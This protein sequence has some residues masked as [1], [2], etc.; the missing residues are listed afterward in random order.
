MTLRDRILL[1]LE[2]N[3]GSFV[4]GQEIAE[5]AGVSRSAVAKCVASL[6]AEGFRIQSVN[7]Q[8][9]L[10]ESDSDILSESGILAHLGDENVKI[11]VFKSI[12]STN[13]EA[14]RRIAQGLEC[15][16]IFASEEQTAGRGRRGKSF[17]SPTSSG[18][19]F[20]AVIHPEVG[21]LDSTAITSAAA[22]AVCE[23]LSEIT[24]KRPKIK[25]VNDIFI[26]G[27]KV[28]GILTEAV[29]DLESG[30]VQ[31]VIVGIGI[32]VTTEDFPEDI[33]DIAGALGNNID[34]CALISD[35]FKR[36]KSFSEQLPD[37]SFMDAY[38]KH[39]L[40]IGKDITFVRNNVDYT[41]HAV[42][43]HDDGG[44]EVVTENAEVV[45]LNS[46]EISIKL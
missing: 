29:S 3:K 44:L 31:A 36:L 34:R 24:N 14:K 46:G 9:H 20:S 18:I 13:S 27:R 38:R 2:K 35:I 11:E 12:D 39:S 42:T 43:I 32:N 19:Y 26:D 7:N 23:A 16:A 5:N 28:C 25:W 33:R 40:V 15:D 4:S 17:Y 21:L 8:G 30:R 10:L 22:V 37:R 1:L 45:I 41:A 6:K